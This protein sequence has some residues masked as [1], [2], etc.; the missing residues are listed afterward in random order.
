M[1]TRMFR[2]FCHDTDGEIGTTEEGKFA[3]RYDGP[4]VVDGA[5]YFD[6][7]SDTFE[8][9]GPVHVTGIPEDTVGFNRDLDNDFMAGINVGS[10]KLSEIYR[11]I[12]FKMGMPE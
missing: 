3:C 2:E 1:N 12:P 4:D 5:V 9:K 8:L 7:D 11:S 10:E 6:P